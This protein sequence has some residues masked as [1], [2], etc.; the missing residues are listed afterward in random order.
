MFHLVLHEPQIPANTGN[1]IR[2]CANS[3]CRL[4]L[5]EPLGFR[6]DRRSVRRAALDY[7]ELAVLTTYASLT[8]C[9]QQLG[10]QGPDG[11]ARRW[12]AIE[13]GSQRAY[14]AARFHPG[15]VLLFG[16]ETRGLP[17]EALQA[18]PESQRLRVPMRPGNRSLNL[19]N[20][21]AIVIYEA[22]RQNGFAFAQG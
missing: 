8:D 5:I 10:E 18:I 14:D 16:A 21:A 22:W 17:P 13:T 20:C 4:H 1:I 3:G 15:D 6:L 9:R 12:F 19:S 7:D 2:L 11:G